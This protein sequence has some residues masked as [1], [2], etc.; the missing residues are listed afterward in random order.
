MNTRFLAGKITDVLTY[1]RKEKNY[2]EHTIRAYR[3]DI[4]GFFDFL[5]EKGISTVDT[6]VLLSFV[7]SLLRYGLEPATVARKLSS[8]KS[9]FKVLKRLGVVSQSPADM[10]RTPRK[11]RHL[12]GVLTYEQIEEGMKIENPRDRA[13]MELLY[14]C[15]LRASE[16]V[17]LNLDD[18]D[19]G[20]EEVRVMGKG[21][22]ERILPMGRIA[23]E[24]VKSYLGARRPRAEQGTQPALFLNYRGGRLTTRSLQNIVRKC[25]VRVARA[26]GTNP[27]V[28]RHS[29]ATHML[30]RGA[31]LRAVQELLGHASL[32]TV[33]IYTHLTAQ[34]LKDVYAKAHPRG[35]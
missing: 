25:L 10:I 22:K 9:F 19:F 5:Q 34:R 28:L 29:F 18:I 17:G 7:A 21:G 26:A 16:L 32:S 15:G 31:N 12:P 20:Q 1:L 4:G 27:H 23:I 35:E 13:M 2:S 30:E 3:Q 8:L 24:A 6:D 33:Q 14:S 11:K